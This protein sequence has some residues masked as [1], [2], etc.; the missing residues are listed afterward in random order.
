MSYWKKLVEFL[1][2]GLSV[3]DLEGSGV[4]AKDSKGRFV[5]DDKSTVDVNEAYKDG[6]TP[7]KKNKKTRTKNKYK[8]IQ[9]P[10]SRNRRVRPRGSK[11][12]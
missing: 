7:T 3:S 1:T 12:K 5:A 4:R 6:K 8:S 9:N 10:K 2:N 11:N